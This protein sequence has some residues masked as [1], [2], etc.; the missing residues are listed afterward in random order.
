MSTIIY[1]GVKYKQT[2]HAVYCKKCKDTIE[3]KWSHDFKY[4][5]CGSVGIDGGIEAGNRLLGNL[6]D[7]E[8]RS[9]YSAVLNNKKKLWLPQE[10]IEEQFIG[11]KVP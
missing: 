5:S 11:Y 6:E 3:S 9:M 10:I 2:R 1:G 4:C 8:S 7:M